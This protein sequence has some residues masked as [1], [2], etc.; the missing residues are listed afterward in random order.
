MDKIIETSKQILRQT[1]MNKDKPTNPGLSLEVNVMQFL[2]GLLLKTSH[3]QLKQ[4]KTP[5]LA[6]LKDSLQLGTTPPA[7]FVLL[8]VFYVFVVR[9]PIAEER[10]CRRELQVSRLVCFRFICAIVF[11]V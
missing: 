3:E 10:R 8:N 11:W 2:H 1:V 5:L 9:V 4:V 7:L 6:L